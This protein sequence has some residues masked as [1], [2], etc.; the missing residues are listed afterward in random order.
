[1]LLDDPG[2]DVPVRPIHLTSDMRE[3]WKLRSRLIR[4]PNHQLLSGA[5]LARDV[6]NPAKHAI[7]FNRPILHAD[8]IASGKMRT[9]ESNEGVELRRATFFDISIVDH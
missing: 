3:Q 2:N 1:M 9:D 7:G 4:R 8:L 5:A 6:A